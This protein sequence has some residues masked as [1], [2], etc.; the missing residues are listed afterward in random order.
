MTSPQHIE[1]PIIHHLMMITKKYLSSFA[2]FTHDIPLE[3]YH[4]ALLYIYQNNQ[5]L[6]QK[7]LAGYFQ[8][9]KSFMVSMI[10]YLSNNDFVYRETSTEDR[11][12]HFIKLT[13]KALAFIPKINEAII[14]TN[15]LALKDINNKDQEV[16]LELIK[17]L[18]VN[19]NV[20]SEHII[21]IDYTKS[22]NPNEN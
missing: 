1:Q 2:D 12:K 19:L 14:K 20:D 5:M 15:Q 9:D 16:L 11:R 8:V 3:R 21:N 13:D 7:D 6:T 18:E 22:K 17:Q 4:Y 10:D